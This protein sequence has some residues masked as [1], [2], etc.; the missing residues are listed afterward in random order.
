MGKADP[1]A[2]D[3]SEGVMARFVD[4]VL[5]HVGAWRTAWAM[6]KQANRVRRSRADTEFLPAAL[7]VMECPPSPIGRW[8]LWLI[9]GVFSFAIAWATLS[10]VD[11]IATA[12]GKIIPTGRVKVIQPL[13]SGTVSDILVKEGQRVREGDLLIELDATQIEAERQQIERELQVAEIDRA[14]WKAVLDNPMDPVLAFH[15]PSGLGKERTATYTRLLR[16]QADAYRS[17]LLAIDNQI[18]AVEAGLASIMENTARMQETLPVVEQELK[19]NRI[20]VNKGVAPRLS[21]GPLE[22]QVIDFR[23]GISAERKKAD[24]A[25]ARITAA[26]EQRKEAVSTYENGALSQYTLS[27]RRIDNFRQELVKLDQRREQQALI[28][29]VDGIVQQLQ[30]HTIGGVVTPAEQLM[31]IVPETSELEAEVMI[32][33]KD[34]GFVEVGQDAVVKLET[35]LFTR[36]G[37]IDGTVLSIS[38]DAIADERLGL[39][40]AARVALNSTEMQVDGRIVPLSP[41]MAATVEVK[42]GQRRIIEFVL[43]PLLRYSQESL[44]ER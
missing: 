26:R 16:T 33:N 36:Y 38:P 4:G 24:E 11:I 31:V 29:P 22:R 2:T 25:L 17:R 21:L 41:G 19:A 30:T 40:Y 43:A 7:E 3:R 18:K 15:P 9:A 13:E 27:E 5:Y 34:I 32:P 20:L 39:V 28:A 12:S 6:E 8:V 42:T 14:R 23:K 10:H 35:F 1:Q 44:R 37:A